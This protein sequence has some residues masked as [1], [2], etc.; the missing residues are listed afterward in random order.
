[1]VAA[2][3]PRYWGHSDVPL[4]AEGVHQA[5]RLGAHLAGE[6]IAAIYSS[7]LRR[8]IETAAAIAEPHR[9]ALTP[10]SELREIDFGLCEGMTFDEIVTRYPGVK[11]VWA[12]LDIDLR[13]PEGESIG[14]LAERTDRFIARFLK[15]WPA[16]NVLI[17]AHGGSLRVLMCR[18]LG[19]S[20]S[21]WWQVRVDLASVTVLETGPEGISLSLSNDL[22]HLVSPGSGTDDSSV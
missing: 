6:A 2:N 14:A 19:M 3:P 7:D 11:D 1:M 16:H 22:S 8:A 5:K 15:P 17:V 4:S 21:S 9:V 20:L 18:L 12:G 13:F 10:C